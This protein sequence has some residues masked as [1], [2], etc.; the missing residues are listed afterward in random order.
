MV[1][2]AQSSVTAIIV[3]KLKCSTYKISVER[4][5]MLVLYTDFSFCSVFIAVNILT[6]SICFICYNKLKIPYQKKNIKK[7][8]LET[9]PFWFYKGFNYPYLV[10]L[11]LTVHTW[12]DSLQM[13]N[14]ELLQETLALHMQ[15]D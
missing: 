5:G 1:A 12:T 4:K 9:L 15:R 11:I 13:F 2:A 6:F 14:C 10:K 3:N 8:V 7:H